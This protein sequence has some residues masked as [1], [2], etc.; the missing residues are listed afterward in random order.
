MRIVGVVLLLVLA[1]SAAAWHRLRPRVLELSATPA[2]PVCEFRDRR[3]VTWYSLTPDGKKALKSHTRSL[4]R[5][6]TESGMG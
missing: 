6:I 4:N 5:M 2:A 3:P 1:I